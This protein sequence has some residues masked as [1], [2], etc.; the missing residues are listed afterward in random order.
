VE[1]RL[2]EVDPRRVDGVLQL[3]QQLPAAVRADSLVVAAP[4]EARGEILQHGLG[5]DHLAGGEQHQLLDRL[6]GALGHRV[7]G[8][9]GLDQVAE[10][11]D[12]DRFGQVGR[13]DVQDAAPD[14]EA[15]AVL[16]DRDVGVAELHQ[17]LEQALALELLAG[18]QVLADLPEGGARDDALQGAGKRRHHGPGPAVQKAHQRVQPLPD[19]V[20]VG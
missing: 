6:Q 10:E 13:E 12:P 17:L 8:A 9:H 11:L 3:L 4:L 15:A 20:W 16:D 14:R 1:E 7:E 2:Q 5:E 19:D 18:Q